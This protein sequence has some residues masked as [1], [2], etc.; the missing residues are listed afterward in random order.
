MCQYW[1]KNPDKNFGAILLEPRPH[2]NTLGTKV[3]A[4]KENADDSIRPVLTVVVSAISVDVGDRLATSWGAIR[5]G[6]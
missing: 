3:F 1:V 6:I 4:S 2:A 5:S